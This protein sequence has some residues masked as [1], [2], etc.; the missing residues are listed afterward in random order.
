MKDH[1]NISL[2]IDKQLYN[3][4]KSLAAYEGRSMNGQL[5]YL[6]NQCVREFE[7][8]HGPIDPAGQEQ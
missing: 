4:F 8:A 1:A 5:L 7:R 2:R 6:V 3:K